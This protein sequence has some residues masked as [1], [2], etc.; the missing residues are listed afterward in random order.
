MPPE[1]EPTRPVDLSALTAKGR[2]PASRAGLSGLR[3][4]NALAKTSATGSAALKKPT[5]GSLTAPTA[6]ARAS[7]TGP[8]AGVKRKV[9]DSEASPAPNRVLRPRTSSSGTPASVAIKRLTA[10]ARGVAP[11]KPPALVGTRPAP[12][13][14]ALAKAATNRPVATAV[15]AMKRPRP[16]V[17]TKPLVASRTIGR[18]AVSR[19]APSSVAAPTSNGSATTAS[20]DPTLVCVMPKKKKR[21]AWDT[22]GRLE[23]MEEYVGFMSQQ[24]KNNDHNMSGLRGELQSSQDKI[25][26]LEQFRENLRS[27]VQVKEQENTQISHQL[28]ELQSALDAETRNHE[29]LMALARSRHAQEMAELNAQYANLKR[30][31]KELGDDLRRTEQTLSLKNDENAQ[32]RATISQQSASFLTLE[33]SCQALKQKLAATETTLSEREVYIADL[34]TQLRDA[35]RLTATLE[36]KIREEETVRRKLHNTIQELKGNIRVFCR[37]RPVLPS[38]LG[39]PGT[40]LPSAHATDDLTHHINYLDNQPP[41]QRH[42][43]ELIQ[44]TDS[45]SG[46]KATTKQHPFSF[47]RIF[48]PASSQ[49]AVF[50]E[51]SQL[52]Q[53]ALDGYPVCIFAYGQTGSGKTHTMEGPDHP[54][55]ATMGMIPRAVRQIYEAAEALRDK[56]W[57]YVM[58]GQFLEIYNESLNDLLAESSTLPNAGS[59]TTTAARKHEIKHLPTGKTVVTDLTT[60]V[61]DAPHKVHHLLK[62]AAQNR[63][64]AATQ[65]NERSS[66]SHS[67]FTLRL[68]GRNA[69][70]DETSEGVLNLIDLAGSERLAQSGSTGDR[71]RETQAINKSLSCLGDVIYAIANRDSHVPYRN[72][73]LTFLLQNSLGGNSKTLMFVNVSPLASNLQETLCSLR[74]ATKVNSCQIGT[75]RR[76]VK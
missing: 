68:N 57:T 36:A 3:R 28:A 34:E 39:D 47:D 43:L 45:A 73:K 40:S 30:E 37:I 10:K 13:T 70:T 23:D 6:D 22:K 56:G 51:I 15:S 48:P 55:E 4:P 9:V 24:L 53:S 63:A 72:S 59:T 35:N 58:E 74:F 20:S 71:L 54:S 18:P 1:A 67:V 7:G 75:A 11:V 12:R 8:T 27:K 46:G 14:T 49:G 76:V 16:G 52:V 44:T 31:A 17:T 29:Q 26:E 5:T 41:G 32:L 69:L 38:D 21:A 60:V 2:Q 66:R 33:S 61:L 62:R 50:E 19:S 25:R 65:C 64:V 42:E